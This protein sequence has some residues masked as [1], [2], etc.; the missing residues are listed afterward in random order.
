MRSTFFSPV[1]LL[2]K[3]TQNFV[4][5]LIGAGKEL[6]LALYFNNA[7]GCSLKRKVIEF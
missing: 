2:G 5:D 1:G 7:F 6:E 3:K 4:Q